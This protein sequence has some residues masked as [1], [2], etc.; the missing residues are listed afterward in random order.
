MSSAPSTQN[1]GFRRFVQIGRVVYLSVEPYAGK[2]AVIAEIVD[3]NRTFISYS[4]LIITPYVVPGLPRST[5]STALGKVLGE[6]RCSGE[7]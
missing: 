5:G 3:R 2:L 4:T 1:E 6:E 7:V